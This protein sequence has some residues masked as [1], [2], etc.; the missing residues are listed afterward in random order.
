MYYL[1][2]TFVILIVKN[3]LTKTSNKALNEEERNHPKPHQSETTFGEH[4]YKHE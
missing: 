3:K 2:D 1:R 4:H